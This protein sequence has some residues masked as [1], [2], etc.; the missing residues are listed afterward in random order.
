MQHGK[1]HVDVNGA[2]AGAPRECG[3]RL[4]R[5]EPALP[6]HRLRRHHH[7]LSSREHGCSGR[8]L[9]IAGAQLARFEHQLALQQVLG[10]SGR[11]P[12]AIF[13]DA[14]GH[15]FVLVFIDGA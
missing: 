1:D 7:R 11:Q 3:I 6:M 9:R 15:D 13:G 4:K 14:D 8:G 5:N 2:I 10:V 12:A